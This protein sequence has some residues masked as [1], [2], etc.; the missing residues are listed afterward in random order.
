M[1]LFKGSQQLPR[2]KVLVLLNGLFVI[3]GTSASIET[4]AYR[5][6]KQASDYLVHKHIFVRTNLVHLSWIWNVHI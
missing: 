2:L 3:Q 1:H 6:Q 5:I 4:T